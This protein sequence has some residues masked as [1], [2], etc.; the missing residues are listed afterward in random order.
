MKIMTMRQLA[1]LL[2]PY[3]IEQ[4]IREEIDP[5]FQWDYSAK[6]LESMMNVV[7]IVDLIMKIELR[8]GV[9]I[10]DD[11]GE[12]MI[13]GDPQPMMMSYW[14]DKRLGELG[15]QTNMMEGN[16]FISEERMAEIREKA[17]EL[18]L[19][20]AALYVQA[21]DAK[22]FKEDLM[23]VLERIG[24]ALEEALAAIPDST[25]DGEEIENLLVAAER[26]AKISQALGKS[27][28]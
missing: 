20:M 10:P 19:N 23:P 25:I 14:R 13:S 28:K 11:L 18:M 27:I 3:T 24:A 2:L 9:D 15:I 6:S 12:K 22:E 8:Y 16:T 5:K 1:E 21:R 4:A 17:E 26:D 7:D